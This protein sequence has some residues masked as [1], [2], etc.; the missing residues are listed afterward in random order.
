ML[1]MRRSGTPLQPK[2]IQT[3]RALSTP[4]PHANLENESDSEDD[5]EIELVTETLRSADSGS[6]RYSL[7]RRV[8]APKRLMVVKTCSG[9]SSPGGE[10]DVAD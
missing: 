8:T 7:R 5:H 6:N 2:W 4:R 1:K 9:S 3:L 10:G